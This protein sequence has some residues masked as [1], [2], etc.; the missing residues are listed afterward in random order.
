MAFGTPP[1]AAPDGKAHVK[2]FIERV[3]DDSP[4]ANVTAAH[5]ADRNLQRLPPPERLEVLDGLVKEAPK[6]RGIQHEVRE[7]Q[8][9]L[10]RAT[11]RDEQLTYLDKAWGGRQN[12]AH[13]TYMPRITENVS[14][15]TTA[16]LTTITKLAVKHQIALPD[17]IHCNQSYPSSILDDDAPAPSPVD[18]EET[19][20]TT[21]Q[22]AQQQ[23]QDPTAQLTDDV[24]I[25]LLQYITRTSR[26][27]GAKVLD[28]LYVQVDNPESHQPP[29]GFTRVCE[30]NEV[31]YIPL[32]HK[33]QGGHWS[34]AVLR[35][36]QAC[37]EHY[38]SLHRQQD[39][40]N[41]GVFVV[42]FLG[43]LL[44]KLRFPT[45]LHPLPTRQK[46]LNIVLD[47]EDEPSTSTRNV[48]LRRG[49]HQPAASTAQKPVEDLGI[50]GP[51]TASMP[52]GQRTATKRPPLQTV[53]SIPQVRERIAQLEIEIDTLSARLDPLIQ[54]NAVFNTVPRALAQMEEALSKAQRF[55]TPG[56]FW[57]SKE[58]A[59]PVNNLITAYRAV[60]SLAGCD[61]QG[62]ADEI[63]ALQAQLDTAR[64]ELLEARHVFKELANASL[65]AA[66]S[67]VPE[68]RRGE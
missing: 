39:S 57:Q 27:P 2:R 58:A 11:R 42:C 28:P 29:V 23:L 7:H 1:R 43:F 46:L 40:I 8:A 56:S 67:L 44:N 38:D 54:R 48:T 53:R 62:G 21:S 18:E 6:L 41:C 66:L 37:I 35:P 63:A 60:E 5:I 59:S 15:S 65:A 19:S 61:P 31:I 14:I 51:K 26:N 16:P 4:V 52:S 33:S 49:Q 22:R 3:V 47:A 25:L 9:K 30:S 36:E 13:P 68:S 50:Q 34:L 64:A 32:H 45:S 24:L 12:W 17:P 55:G 10:R 20:Q